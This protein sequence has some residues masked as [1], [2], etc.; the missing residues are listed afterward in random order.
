MAPRPPETDS[1]GTE[2]SPVEVAQAVSTELLGTEENPGVLSQAIKRQVMAQVEARVGEMGL[3]DSINEL[4]DAVASRPLSADP[5]SSYPQPPW[6]AQGVGRALGIPDPNWHNPEAAGAQLDGEFNGFG[7]FVRAVFMRDRRGI[8]DERLIQ[9]TSGGSIQASANAE[10]TGQEI[11]W[12][13]LSS[14]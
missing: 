5:A 2:L 9:V 3:A 10:L 1:P 14:V 4:R 11:G 6:A 13:D 7:D 12:N 8:A